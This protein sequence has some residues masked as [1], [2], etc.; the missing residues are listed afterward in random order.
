MKSSASMR[1]KTSSLSTNSPR[2]AD[3]Q[4]SSICFRISALR[5]VKNLVPLF[6]ESE[7]LTNHLAR[8]VVAAGFNLAL[9]ELFELWSEADVHFSLKAFLP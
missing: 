5:S 9:D 8:G 3:C 6:E 4:P 7:G 1:S 2:L